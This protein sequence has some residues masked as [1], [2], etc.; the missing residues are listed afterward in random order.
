[1]RLNEIVECA[2][3]LEVDVPSK[4]GRCQTCGSSAVRWIVGQYIAVSPR[5]TV[6]QET[7]M[8]GIDRE[9]LREIGVQA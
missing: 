7:P 2:E 6:A 1:M 3:C 9:F 5:L 8:C 4:R